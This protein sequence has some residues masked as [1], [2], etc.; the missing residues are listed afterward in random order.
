[1]ISVLLRPQSEN[2]TPPPDYEGSLVMNNEAVQLTAK[3]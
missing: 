1:M 2:S 3:E